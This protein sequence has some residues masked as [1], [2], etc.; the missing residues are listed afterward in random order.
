MGFSLKNINGQICSNAVSK[1]VE[2]KKMNKRPN[3]GQIY[4]E[5]MS[6]Q[7]KQI[8]ESYRILKVLLSFVKTGFNK[9]TFS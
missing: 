5:N 8:S 9:K 2:L 3:K 4:G 1:K 7:Y 6:K